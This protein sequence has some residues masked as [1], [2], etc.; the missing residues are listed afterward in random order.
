LTRL[1][2]G[3]GLLLVVLFGLLAFTPLPNGWHAWTALPARLEPADA[4]VVL[5][6]AVSR[7]G[8]LGPHSLLRTIEGVRLYHLGLAPRILLM[9]PGRRGGPTEASVRARLA[10]ELGVPEQALDLEARGTTTRQEARLAWERLGQGRRRVLLVT[11]SFHMLRARALFARAG[12]QVLPAPTADLDPDA[13]EPLSRLALSRGLI[14]E[15][16]ARA[17]YR[18]FGYV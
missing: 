2:R 1:L 8:V 6:A 18:A 16:L 17:Y 4:V 7:Q 3:L 14:Q 9:G 15:L 13:D 10:R 11:G 5:G 12:F